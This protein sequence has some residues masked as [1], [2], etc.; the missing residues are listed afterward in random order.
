M[1][2][3][4]RGQAGH[5]DAPSSWGLDLREALDTL[6]CGNHQVTLGVEKE[7]AGHLRGAAGARREVKG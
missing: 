5:G 1:D 7:P 4:G 6:A 2:P 3:S